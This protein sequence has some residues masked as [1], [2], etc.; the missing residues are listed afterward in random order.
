VKC[1]RDKDPRFIHMLHWLMTKPGP[2]SGR[3]FGAMPFSWVFANSPQLTRRVSE[4]TS[5]WSYVTC[6]ENA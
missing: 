3:R 5:N 1:Q 2:A 6:F 4:P